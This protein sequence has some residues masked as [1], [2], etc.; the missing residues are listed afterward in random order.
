[1]ISLWEH[2]V[3]LLVSWILGQ[4][5]DKRLAIKVDWTKWMI[6]LLLWKCNTFKAIQK[7][8]NKKGDFD[9]EHHY[10]IGE[11]VG[12]VVCILHLKHKAR[13]FASDKRPFSEIRFAPFFVSNKKKYLYKL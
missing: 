10:F 3:F 7:Q 1:M 5:A 11:G 8:G 13:T 9:F 2:A 4:K 12:F 6:I